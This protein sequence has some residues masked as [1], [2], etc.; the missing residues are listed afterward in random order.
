MINAMLHQDDDLVKASLFQPSNEL[1]WRMPATER[2][3]PTQWRP[4]AG[5][6]WTV[7]RGFTFR[8][9]NPKFTRSGGEFVQALMRETGKTQW[10]VGPKQLWWLQT[11]WVTLAR[12]RNKAVARAAQLQQDKQPHG[13]EFN[14]IGTLCI[15][16]GALRESARPD[17]WDHRPHWAASDADRPSIVSQSIG[18]ELPTPSF[19]PFIFNTVVVIYPPN[20]ASERS[21][22][23]E[24]VW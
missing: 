5:Q 17:I 4:K 3:P 14:R 19:I 1:P 8:R 7:Y 18:D 20:A 16:A 10:K 21:V 23:L 24:H 9:C 13:T 11:R 12:R 6:P 2:G 15:P 22:T